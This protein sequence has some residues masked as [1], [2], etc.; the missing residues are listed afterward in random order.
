MWCSERLEYSS[1]YVFNRQVSIGNGGGNDG[2]DTLEQVL[3]NKDVLCL[4][5]APLFKSHSG[6]ES[7]KKPCLMSS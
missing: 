4:S 6:S 3:R 2:F 5:K 1:Q 7:L